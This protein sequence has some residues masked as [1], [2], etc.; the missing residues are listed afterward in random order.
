M[1]EH[2]G[3]LIEV[4]AFVRSHLPKSRIILCGQ[5]DAGLRCLLAA[6]AADA[7]V[8]D[9][10]KFDANNDRLWTSRE[11][12][13]P[14]IQRIGGFN[15]PLLLAAPNPVFIHNTGDAFTSATLRTT[16]QNLDAPTA[17]KVSKDYEPD[18]ALLNWINAL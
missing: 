3:D 12:I 9:V 8:A 13:I 10:R 14:A 4:C 16:Y 5:D 18:Q 1:Q 6:P 7:V 2:V 17:L 15:G 11:M